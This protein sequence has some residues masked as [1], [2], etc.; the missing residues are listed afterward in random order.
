MPAIEVA[1][2]NHKELGDLLKKATVCISSVGP[3]SKHGEVVVQACVEQQTHYLD[4]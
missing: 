2:L 4:V 3:F 1:Q